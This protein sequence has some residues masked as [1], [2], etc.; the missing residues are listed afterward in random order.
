MCPNKR[1]RICTYCGKNGHTIDRCFQKRDYRNDGRPDAKSKL[2]GRDHQQFLESGI[3][4]HFERLVG[5]NTLTGIHIE[6]LW[7]TALLD[8]G[9]NISTVS[10]TFVNVLLT[11]F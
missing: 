5:E 10:D 6:G 9:S 2:V 8:T 4:K 11:Y 3:G 7:C 1:Q